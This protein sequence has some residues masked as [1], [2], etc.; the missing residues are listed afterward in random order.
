MANFTCNY[1]RAKA[2]SSKR[3]CYHCNEKA[4]IISRIKA[5]LDP[6]LKNRGDKNGT[7][8]YYPKFK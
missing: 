7:S 5:M 6:L 8:G 2:F 1:C 3:L 4:K